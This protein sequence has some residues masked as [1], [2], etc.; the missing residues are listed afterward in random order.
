MPH[1]QKKTK[2]KENSKHGRHYVQPLRFD[3]LKIA[4]NEHG[5]NTCLTGTN[6]DAIVDYGYE[7]TGGQ[8]NVDVY[9][10]GANRGRANGV[11]DKAACPTGPGPQTTFR[12]F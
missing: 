2:R 11:K 8:F 10:N 6:L 12:R 9:V 5:V 1:Y 3:T 7:S 4:R